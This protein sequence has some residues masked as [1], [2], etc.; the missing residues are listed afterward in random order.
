MQIA[1]SDHVMFSRELAF[2][3]SVSHT[4]ICRWKARDLKETVLRGKI[5]LSAMGKQNM[6]AKRSIALQNQTL[7]AQ[8]SQIKSII[9]CVRHRRAHS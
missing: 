8:S 1:Y 3:F 2:C 4:R 5:M 6:Q 7:S 9:D